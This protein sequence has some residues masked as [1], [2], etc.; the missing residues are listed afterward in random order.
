MAVDVKFTDNSREAMRQIN[1][2]FKTR[3]EDACMEVQNTVVETL[4]GSRSGRFYYVPGTRKIYQA[5]A[6]G[7]P[8]ATA[9]A[10]LRQSIAHE[11]SRDGR[12]GAVGTDIPYGPGLEYGT[13]RV[14]ARPWLRRSFEESLLQ[15]AYRRL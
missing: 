2:T 12:V 9:T 10:R 7:E 6:P 5:S 11:V 8:P 15:P 14:A 13:K 4:S 3:M 1:Q